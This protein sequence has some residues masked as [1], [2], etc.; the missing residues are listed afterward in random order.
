MRTVVIAAAFSAIANAEIPSVTIGK[1]ASGKDVILPLVGSG[2]WEYNN[3]V[4]YD[5]LCKA[6]SVGYTFVD[7]AN[8]YGNEQGVGD[9][10]KDCWI[11]AGKARED[12]FVMTKIPG[13]LNTTEVMAAHD[14]NMELL[15]LDYVDHLMTHFPGDWNENPATSNPAMR[16]EEW[17]ALESIYYSG[18]AR[19]IGVSHYCTSHINDVLEVATVIPSINQVE[20]HVGSGDVDD[21]MQTCADNGIYFMSFSPLCGPCHYLPQYSLIDGD[22]VTSIGEKYNVSGSQVSLRWIVQQAIPGS[23][24]ALPFVAGV[25]P[26][27]DTLSHIESNL[28]LFNFELSQEDMDTLTEQTKPM[29]TPGDCACP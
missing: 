11:G 17:L 27:S 4:A 13:G 6:F 18:A 22:L 21:V 23:P 8:G 16:Q 14:E 5:S 24:G 26:K 7:T 29:A 25:I 20:Y 9:A 10:I 19:S 3:S 15:G 12:L 1:D 28:D 2:T